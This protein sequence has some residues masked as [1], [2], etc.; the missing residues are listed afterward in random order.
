MGTLTFG[1]VAGFMV[2]ALPFLL[3]KAGISVDRIATVSAAAMSPMFWAFLLTPIV[4]AGFTRRTYAFSLGIVSAVSLAA[5]L[6]LFSPDRLFLFT[7][8][9]LLGELAVALQ[10]SAVSGWTTEFLTDAQRGQVGGWM[11]VANLGGGA[12]VSMFIMWLATYLPFRV[13]GVVLALMVLAS[14]LVLLRFPRAAK[15]VVSWRRIFDGTF[16]SVVLTSKQPQVLIGFLLFLAPA[17]CVAAINLFAGLGKDFHT[18]P[19]QV[20][21]ITGAGAALVTAVGSLLGGY[22]AD[23]MDRGV[24]YMSGGMLAGLCSL[25]LALTS[26][27]QLSFAS[28]V[29]IYNGIAGICYAAFSALELQLTGSQNP[30]A[31]TQLGLFGAAANAAVVYMTWVDGQGYRLLSVRGLF[32][33]DGIAAIGAAIPLLLLL[34]WHVRK[35]GRALDQPR[36]GAGCERLE[37]ELT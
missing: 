3:T 15:P 36:R 12:L 4:D 37:D 33:A 16:R 13:L 7:A 21:W 2:T 28:G 9:A 35:H 34:Q 5:A 26:H 25:A 8:F 32:L 29:L 18:A 20:V 11:N 30:T 22:L 19:Q 6:W 14:T 10:G 23:K 31:A 1:L 17:S 27:T 24:L